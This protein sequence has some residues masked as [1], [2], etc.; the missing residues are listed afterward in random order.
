ML[1]FP[2]Q[3]S[4]S[5]NG[6]F[7]SQI[8]LQN[9][10]ELKRPKGPKGTL[11]KSRLY[12]VSN[13]LD[14]DKTHQSSIQYTLENLPIKKAVFIDSTWN[15]CR[16]IYKDERIKRLRPIILQNRLSQF[17]RHQKGSPR[18]YLA[19]IEGILKNQISLKF[20]FIKIFKFNFL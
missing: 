5:V 19:T 18:W 12:E 6:I 20:T 1:I 17:W 9:P 13:N 8:R 10:E 2:A 15:Q 7:D 11:I 14:D 3:N 16:A 4:T